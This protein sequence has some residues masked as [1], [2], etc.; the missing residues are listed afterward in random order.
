M[1]R[2]VLL[3]STRNASRQEG[4]AESVPLYT[5]KQSLFVIQKKTTELSVSFNR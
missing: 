4:A 3:A 5:V 2:A 1:S